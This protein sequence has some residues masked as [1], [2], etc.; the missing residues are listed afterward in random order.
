MIKKPS[1]FNFENKK[2]AMIIAGVAGIGKTTLA[3]SSPRPLLIDLD[4]GVDR[5]EMQYRKDTIFADTYEEVMNDLQTNDLSDYETIVV[6]TGGKL[7]ELLKPVVIKEN[8]KNGKSNGDLSLQGY[9]AVKRKFSEFIK[10]IK[11]LGKNIIII[12][13]ASEVKLDNDMTGLRIRIEGSS[14]DEVWD[15]MDLGGFIEINNKQRTISFTNCD[16]F[17]AKGTHGIHGTYVIPDTNKTHKND[18]ITKLWKDY[19]NEIK[20]ETEEIKKYNEAMSSVDFSKDVNEIYNQIKNMKHYLTSKEELQEKLKE[21]I[22]EKGLVY[23]KVSDKFI[24]N[25]EPNK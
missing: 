1:E 21:L 2:I 3:L 20:E 25:T 19:H 8:I 10:F 18:F 16:R 14:K 15:D 17:Y 13:H 9:G 5:V 12:F 23:D 6:D 24:D 22:K 11:G 7:L 4:K